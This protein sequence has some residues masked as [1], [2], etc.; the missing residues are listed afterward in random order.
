[1]FLAEEPFVK[2][3]KM[4]FSRVTEF[5]PAQFQPILLQTGYLAAPFAYGGDV[6]RRTPPEPMLWRL[7]V[8]AGKLGAHHPD[9]P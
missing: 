9:F 7:R 2:A 8:R 5:F 6:V 3:G 4:R 1:V